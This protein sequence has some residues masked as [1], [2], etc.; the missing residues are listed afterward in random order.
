M[1]NTSF[2]QEEIKQ[3]RLDFLQETINDF[4]LNNR[5]IVKV[6]EQTTACC[7]SH[8]IN[9]GCAIGRKCS[10]ELADKLDKNFKNKSVIDNE[11]FNLLPYELQI[12]G[13][14]FLGRVQSLHDDDTYWDENG[15]SEQGKNYFQLIQSNY[16]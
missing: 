2:S 4:N 11:V 7:Y 10:A 1:T 3:K 12:L 9:G 5:A 16:L 15:L 13:P 8:K 6:S 14:Y